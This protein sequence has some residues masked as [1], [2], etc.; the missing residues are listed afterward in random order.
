MEIA[1]VALLRSLT[2]ILGLPHPS[3]IV[4]LNDCCCSWRAAAAVA[5]FEESR[6]C[7]LHFPRRTIERKRDTLG[8]ELLLAEEKAPSH[9]QRAGKGIEELYSD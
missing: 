3:L 6:P 5:V 2:V 1:L 9:A 8:E 7:R 4:L